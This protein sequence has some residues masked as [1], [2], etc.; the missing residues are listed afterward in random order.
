MAVEK[1]IETDNAPKAI[2]PYSQAT[3][4][5]G[6]TLVFVSGQIPID[7][8]TGEF[9]PGGIVEQTAQCLENMEAILEAAEMERTDV[10]KCTVFLKNMEDFA[11]MNKVY[12]DFFGDHK[13]ARAAFQV[14]ALPKGA[15]VEIEAIVAH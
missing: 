2:G 4:V 14:G 9:V 3:K 11:D 12:G 15:L 6:C 13:P 10:A 8:K 1:F 7:P 5:S